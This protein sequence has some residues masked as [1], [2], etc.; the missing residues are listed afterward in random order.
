MGRVPRERSIMPFELDLAITL[1][2]AVLF[3]GFNFYETGHTDHFD[4]HIGH[5]HV[6]CE[7]SPRG[8]EYVLVDYEPPYSPFLCA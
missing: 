8:C 6:H 1:P 2:Y 7:L 5:L 4:G 3:T